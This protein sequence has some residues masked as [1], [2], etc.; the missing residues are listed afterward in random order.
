MV[1][2][3]HFIGLAGKAI[4]SPAPYADVV[5]FTTH[6]V[7]RGPRRGMTRR[8]RPS[9]RRRIDKA[10]FPMMQGGRLARRAWRRRRL[11]LKEAAH[12]GVPKA[13]AEPAAIA[14]AQRRS[15]PGLE[16]STACAR[17]A[18]GGTDTHL[19]LIHIAGAHRASR[20]RHRRGALR[21]RAESP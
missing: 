3:A 11:A 8:A 16:R 12:A 19:A 2:A 15:P 18:S 1:D 20:R 13:Y 21:R 4:P 7:L 6:K 10:V 14:N 17:S 9:T 5:T